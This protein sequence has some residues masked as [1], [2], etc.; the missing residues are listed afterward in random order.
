MTLL[1]V[2]P[3]HSHSSAI[4]PPEAAI[5]AP[6][7]SRMLARMHGQR[8]ATVH[9]SAPASPDAVEALRRD[10][11]ILTAMVAEQHHLLARLAE[12]MTHR[13]DAA[14][15]I[16][17]GIASRPSV[18]IE[19]FPAHRTREAIV[20]RPGLGRGLEALIPPRPFPPENDAR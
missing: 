17:D 2:P 11:A 9:A 5:P 12:G 7:G 16:L 14:E 1:D 15:R 6:F 19:P 8:L 20:R 10:I 18:P 13:L 3:I 4:Q